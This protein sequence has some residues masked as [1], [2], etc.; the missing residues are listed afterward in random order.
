MASPNASAITGSELIRIVQDGQ[1]RLIN[2]SDMQTLVTLTGIINRRFL[3]RLTEKSGVEGILAIQGGQRIELSA[4]DLT[5]Y[6]AATGPLG[7]VPLDLRAEP[8]TGRER[9]VVNQGRLVAVDLSQLAY[10]RGLGG[11]L[12]GYGDY[13]PPAGGGTPTPTPT[14]STILVSAATRLAQATGAAT[15]GATSTNNWA[16]DFIWD[17]TPV[18]VT[19]VRAAFN[20][21]YISDANWTETD[22]ASYME[23]SYSILTNLQGGNAA[24]NQTAATRSNAGFTN[25]QAGTT[26][27]GPD[28]SAHAPVQQRTG[29]G[30][31]TRYTPSTWANLLTAL[32]AIDGTITS[33]VDTTG[34]YPIIKVAPGFIIWSDAIA[35]IPVGGFRHLV[36]SRGYR[37]AA[38][39]IPSNFPLARGAGWDYGRPSSTPANAPFATADWS[40]QT[41]FST[42]GGRPGPLVLMGY[43]ASGK[44]TILIG[45]DSI[46]VG[47]LGDNF[48]NTNGASSAT[49]RG[50]NDAGYPTM[51]S[52][53]ASSKADGFNTSVANGTAAT[54][55]Y[56][57]SLV[58]TEIHEFGHNA[59]STA[60]AQ[61][62][63][64]HSTIR[65]MMFG[66]KRVIAS[67]LLCGPTGGIV[68]GALALTSIVSGGTTTA[69][70]TAAA[71]HGLATGDYVLI[72]K[73]DVPGYVG[74][75]QVTVTTTTAYTFACPAGTADSTTGNIGLY[76]KRG[77]PATAARVTTY[78]P[79][80]RAGGFNIANGD[81]DLAW[82][83]ELAMR[84]NN[85]ADVSG[86]S[87]LFL[88][89]TREGTH[90]IGVQVDGVTSNAVI[91]CAADLASK[92]TALF[93]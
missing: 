4:A 19:G 11:S 79:N 18:A 5:T 46:A 13:D 22:T 16:S 20:A 37:T 66:R 64:Y 26:F 84:N 61:N 38:L 86:I 77:V 76:A 69:T 54:A 67:T 1:P 72:G 15:G 91:R 63:I 49:H 31:S 44:P 60:L 85:A 33:P 93:A 71:A 47:A 42:T 92:A 81:P 87:V 73:C 39:P 24:L 43:S 65:S 88:E 68:S 14:P 41:G 6:L 3:G 50:A 36:L 48:G 34:T 29:S 7:L 89:E 56:L 90:P 51:K 75:F 74:K 10:I 70:A 25:A 83:F 82:D 78:N 8:F 58:S 59:D 17:S 40:S 32:Q 53:V 57:R 55:L 30:A 9:V 23:Y 2:R 45:G 52:A 28:G 80:L 12:A 27:V 21:S 62:R 35:D